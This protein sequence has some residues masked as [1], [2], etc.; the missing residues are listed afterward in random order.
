MHVFV[1]FVK[2]IAMLVSDRFLQRLFVFRCFYRRHNLDVR[3]CKSLHRICCV[4]C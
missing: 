3:H 2:Y 1:G 4:F